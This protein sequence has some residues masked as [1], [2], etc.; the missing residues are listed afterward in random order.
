NMRAEE[1]NPVRSIALKSNRIPRN[2]R[3]MKRKPNQVATAYEQNFWSKNKIQKRNKKRNSDLTRS[4]SDP[5]RSRIRPKVSAI[6]AK[7]IPN[8]PSDLRP[9]TTEVT[10]SE[11]S[12]PET[13]PRINPKKGNS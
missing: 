1:S 8:I 2:E 10:S 9:I 11:S 13:N 5:T 6:T 7:V 3:E 4:N 12:P